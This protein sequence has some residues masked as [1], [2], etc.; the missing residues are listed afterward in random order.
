MK[1]SVTENKAIV[2]R[3]IEEVLNGGHFELIDELFAARLQPQVKEIA[4]NLHRAFPDMHE[5]IH[6][7]IAEDHIVSAR[8]TFRG[9]QN[10]QF[11]M[12]PPTGKVVE[13]DG[14]SI[15]YIED[16]KI[17]DDLAV[18]D[19]VTALQQLGARILPPI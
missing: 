11:M 5:T 18:L 16:G 8:W 15:Y 3:Y 4:R 7:M 2:R 12:V 9:T 19:L 10:G 6:D 13:F 14:L 17:A 1:Q